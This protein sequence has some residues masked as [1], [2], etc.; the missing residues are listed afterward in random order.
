M[1]E[2]DGRHIPRSCPGCKSKMTQPHT[3][4]YDPA[5]NTGY[6]VLWQ[7][8][9]CGALLELAVNA[10]KLSGYAPVVFN[11]GL[12]EYRRTCNELRKPRNE[13]R[14]RVKSK[15]SKEKP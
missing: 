15:T 10:F 6:T 14:G 9:D 3:I 1:N 11:G 12:R 7:C 13:R 4:L 8:L 2:A 5:S